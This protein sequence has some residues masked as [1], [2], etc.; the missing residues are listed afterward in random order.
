M[1]RAAV[2]AAALALLT[3]ACGGPAG[4]P[5]ASN[6]VAA[7]ANEAAPPPAPTS[8]TLRVELATS[9]G[10]IVVAL[11][12]DHAPVTA[13]N[14]LAY[15]DR[16]RFDRTSFYR[17]ARTHGTAGRGFVQ[18]GIR[19]DYTRMLAPIAMEPTSRTGLRHVD[20][21]I[22][23]ARTQEGAGAM[24]D[25]FIIVGGAMPDMDAG[26]RAGGDHQGYAAFG[27]VVAGMDVVR[28]I[29]AAPTTPNAGRGA[30]RGQ[31]IAAPVR[32]SSARR[33]S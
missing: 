21:T 11:D 23:M 29:L 22:S 12:F 3:A 31:M 18:G 6:E 8:G 28:H 15:V 33:A 26:P 30:M 19:H 1:I 9:A 20:G 25:F 10:P 27:H 4:A 17:A 2:L 24:G 32:I 7:A 14:F 13:G 16:H 5:A